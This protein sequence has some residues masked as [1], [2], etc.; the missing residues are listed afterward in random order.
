MHIAHLVSTPLLVLVAVILLSLA[1]LK[2]TLAGGSEVTLDLSNMPILIAVSFLLGSSP[3]PLWNL[4]ERSAK[5]IT[6]S[7]TEK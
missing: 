7:R 6:G 1:T 5:S 4:I 3:W 2:V